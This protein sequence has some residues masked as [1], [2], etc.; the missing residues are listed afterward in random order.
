[1][2]IWKCYK[3]VFCIFQNLLSLNNVDPKQKKK[4]RKCG[5]AVVT[6]PRQ[7]LQTPCLNRG[8][9]NCRVI[10]CDVVLPLSRLRNHVRSLHSDKLVEVALNLKPLTSGLVPFTILGHDRFPRNL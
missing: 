4:K 6:V 7:K 2:Q 10:G 8:V 1:M 5:P 3:P 9:Y